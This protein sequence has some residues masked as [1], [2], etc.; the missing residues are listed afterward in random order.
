MVRLFAR[1]AGIFTEGEPVQM[2]PARTPLDAAAM[3]YPNSAPQR[4]A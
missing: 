1:I 2:Q 3:V 4:G